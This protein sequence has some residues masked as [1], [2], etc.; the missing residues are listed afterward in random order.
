MLTASVRAASL[1]DILPDPE[2]DYLA[3]ARHLGR[4]Q[5]LVEFGCSPGPT[6]ADGGEWRVEYDDEGAV[7]ACEC[8]SEWMS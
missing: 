7:I 6:V 2:H 8:V 1:D 5:F 3:H 4:R